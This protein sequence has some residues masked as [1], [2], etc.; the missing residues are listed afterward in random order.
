MAGETRE[1]LEREISRLRGQ[2]EERRASIPIHSIRPHQLVEIEELEE[3]IRELDL[4][5]LNHSADP[6]PQDAL[7]PSYTRFLTTSPN[8]RPSRYSGAWFG[9]WFGWGSSTSSVSLPLIRRIRLLRWGLSRARN[10]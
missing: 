6:R 8:K 3:A 2:L 1:A 4:G 10:P 5:W 9:P 7:K